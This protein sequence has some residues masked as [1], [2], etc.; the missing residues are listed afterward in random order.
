[1][2]DNELK[3]ALN[4]YAQLL[5]VHGLN[6]QPG[7]VVQIASEVCNREFALLV[8]EHAYDAGAKYVLLDFSEPRL[9]RKRILNSTEE[10]LGYV[11]R[12]LSVRYDDVVNEKGA[13][14]RL[15]GSEDPLLLADLDPKRI[16][17]AQ[18][19]IRKAIKYFYDEG[20]GKSK[21]HWTVAA[22]STA[23]WGKRLFPG[24]TSEVAE[25]KLWESILKVCRADREDCLEAWQ[26]HNMELQRR[27][28]LFTEMKIKSLHFSGPGTDLTVSLSQK[29]VF[30]GG[31]DMGPRGVEF[32]PNIPTEEV[33]TTPDRRLCASVL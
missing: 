32:E 16:N 19:A 1:M 18:L 8:A 25:R 21:V 27:A 31:R 4:R 24:T 2:T 23:G 6:V 3:T 26:K 30:K 17:T 15:I 14:L 33:F 20:I 13:N 11:P 22:A 12:W 7:Q 9:M 28:K 5:V 10:N 29:A